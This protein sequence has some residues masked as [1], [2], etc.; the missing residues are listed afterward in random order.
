MSNMS[1]MKEKVEKISNRFERL[2]DNIFIET[3][4]K[5]DEGYKVRRVENISA[6]LIEDVQESITEGLDI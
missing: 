5:D 1:L 4:Y 2:L 3:D 6:Q